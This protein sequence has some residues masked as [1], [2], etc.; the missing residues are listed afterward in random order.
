MSIQ[1]A[2]V[3]KEYKLGKTIVNALRGISLNIEQGEFVA[4][5]GP[6]GSGKSTTLHILGAL[7]RPTSGE[8]R[9]K[10]TLVTQMSDKELARLRRE[11]IGFIFQSFNLIPVLSVYG[12]VEFPLLLMKIPKKERRERVMST[13][14]C[15]GLAD[16]SEHMTEELSGG[17]RQRVAIARALVTNPSIILSD[18]PTANLDSKTGKAIVDLMQKLNEE[19][20]VT[21]VFATHDA[22]IMERA[23]RIVH[24]LDG[25]IVN[26][27]KV[28]D[29]V[30]QRYLFYFFFKNSIEHKSFLHPL[31]QLRICCLAIKCFRHYIYFIPPDKLQ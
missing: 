3:T 28:R 9:I 17:Q 15:V 27:L 10:E 26:N 18:E 2:S 6:S 30:S 23:K 5:V 22:S 25:A 20:H 11:H 1:I 13:L 4:L 8:V 21:L 16:R 24:I 7:D 29:V 12:N 19:Q 14:N 31:R